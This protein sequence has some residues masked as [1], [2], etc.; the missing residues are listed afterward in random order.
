MVKKAEWDSKQKGCCCFDLPFAMD[1]IKISDFY[2]TVVYDNLSYDIED[3][4]D[5]LGSCKIERSSDIE[6]CCFQEDPHV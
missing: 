3:M 5:A 2:N 4:Q 1:S 6:F